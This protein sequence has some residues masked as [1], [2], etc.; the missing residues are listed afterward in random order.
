ML[1]YF[2]PSTSALINRKDPYYA[3]TMF[4]LSSA[5]STTGSSTFIDRSPGNFPITA[6]GGVTFSNEVSK[7]GSNSIKFSGS[8]TYLHSKRVA[9]QDRYNFTVEFW[10]Y[11]TGHVAGSSNPAVLID[12]RSDSSSGGNPYIVIASNGQVIGNVFSGGNKWTSSA[13]NLNQWYHVAVSKDGTTWRMFLN[14]VQVGSNYT[15]SADIL[16]NN[17][18]TIGTYWNQR[19][20][21]TSYKFAGYIDDVRIMSSAYT[22]N[23]TPATRLNG[24]TGDYVSNLEYR[25]FT[26]RR[27]SDHILAGSSVIQA[28][29]LA[30]LYASV[31]SNVTV[32]MP[33]GWTESLADVAN[34]GIKYRIGFKIITA[35]DIGASI[36]VIAGGTNPSTIVH[37][38]RPT[39]PITRVYTRS[40]ANWQDHNTSLSISMSRTNANS[41]FTFNGGSIIT[42]MAGSTN[43]F[44]TYT[45]SPAFDHTAST[46]TSGNLAAGLT[47]KPRTAPQTM[48][49]PDQGN[50][51]MALGML[52]VT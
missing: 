18:V 34:S 11:R 43:D 27:G 31:Y 28:G 21:N 42:G 35:E 4:Q 23:F 20:N 17:D 2:N 15:S 30:L 40:A 49:M 19:T 51:L 33:T 22:S 1:T 48:S 16:P 44:T 37:Y 6:A 9:S 38:L 25:G 14:G 5:K 10:F 3:R 7:F 36:S 32:T 29:D 47:I 13:T 50:N 39:R 45:A 8:G 46:V 52:F 41:E 12:T 24:I 26:Q